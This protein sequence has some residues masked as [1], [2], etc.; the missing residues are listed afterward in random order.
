VYSFQFDSDGNLRVTSSG[1]GGGDVTIVGQTV[2][3]NTEDAA[4]GIIGSPVGTDAIQIGYKDGSGNL[5]IPSAANPLPVTLGGAGGAVTIQVA[6]AAPA[7]QNITVVD[8]ASTST[9][10]ANGASFITGVPTTNS[11]ASFALANP[12][13]TVSFQVTGTWTGTLAIE[14]SLDGGTTWISAGVHQQGTQYFASNFT[15]N[16]IGEHNAASYTN[17]RVRATAAMTGTATVKIVETLNDRIGYLANGITIRDATVQSIS[18]T[19]K[20]AGTPPTTSDTALVTRPIARKSTSTLTTTPLA[21]NGVFTSAWFD[22]NQTGEVWVE[23]TS[24]ADQA[25]ASA[26]FVVQGSDDSSNANFTKTLFA[27]ASEAASTLTQIQGPIPTR[28]W[29]VVYT[30][31]ATL[32]GVFELNVTSSNFTPGQ[33]ISQGA[34]AANQLWEPVIT[35][36]PAIGDAQT[37]VGIYDVSLVARVLATMGG[38]TTSAASGASYVMARTP[39]VFRGGMAQAGTTQIWGPAGSKKPRLMKYKLEIGEDSSYASANTPVYL[40]WIMLPPGTNQPLGPN[41]PT[42]THRVQIPTTALATNGVL[43]D[44]DWI[45]LGNGAVTQFSNQAWNLAISIAQPAS[46]TT[47][48]WTIT[49]NQ[50]EAICFGF[51]SLGNLGGARLRSMV[52]ATGVGSA[53]TVSSNFAKGSTLIAIVRTTNIAAGAPTIAITDSQGVATWTSGTIV[54]NASDGTNGSSIQI[55]WITAPLANGFSSNTVTATT[56]THVAT[57]THMM[58]LEVGNLVAAAGGAT[59]TSGTGNSTAPAAG[60]YT[61]SEAGDYIVSFFASGANITAPVMATATFQTRGQISVSGGT[62]AFADN[63]G[64]GTFA[65]GG[66]NTLAIGTEE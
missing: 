55:F 24:F 17:V 50:W 4:D 1:G 58:V 7:T 36:S 2:T 25:G 13:A 34:G 21:G 33:Y 52:Q 35:G 30:N 43:W 31:G 60:A 29:R 62:L 18:T 48:T 41:N 57:L 65:A 12:S 9:T 16:F 37:V 56:S 20:A 11:A 64:N 54:T 14:A 45:D 27:T 6:D 39:N 28:Y 3:L 23:A 53:V 59:Q 44:S 49:S 26:G 51:K 5:Q 40:D 10:V 38:F 61:P 8:S 15:A 47:P 19:V 42:L 46:P 22:T 66:V 63:I 32:Q